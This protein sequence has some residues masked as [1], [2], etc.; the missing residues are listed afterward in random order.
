[1]SPSVTESGN[2]GVDTTLISPKNIAYEKIVALLLHGQSF[3]Q[4]ITPLLVN[5][6]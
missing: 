1:M 6:D 2:T 4:C 3:R 5:G